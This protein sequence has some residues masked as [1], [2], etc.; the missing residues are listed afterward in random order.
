MS[1]ADAK[2]TIETWRIDYNTVRPHS[3]L[4]GTTREQFARIREGACRLT[5]A[6]PDMDDEDPKT[7]GP[8]IIRVADF[9]GRSDELVRRTS[10]AS[11]DARRALLEITP[12]YEH[13]KPANY[14]LAVA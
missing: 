4:D 1:L 13:G 7:R 2:A 10:G 6:R 8:H 11:P 9:G 14:I 5:P 3:S 12:Y